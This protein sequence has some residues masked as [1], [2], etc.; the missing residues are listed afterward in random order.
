MPALKLSS[1]T[2]FTTIGWVLTADALVGAFA[3]IAVWQSVAEFG[4]QFPPALIYLLTFL[5]LAVGGFVHILR[6]Q[7]VTPAP[8]D[9]CAIVPRGGDDTHA[10]HAPVSYMCPMDS[11][12]NTLTH[13]WLKRVSPTPE[14][15]FKNQPFSRFE[16]RLTNLHLSNPSPLTTSG[17]SVPKTPRP[18]RRSETKPG[19]TP[20]SNRPESAPFNNPR[21]DYNHLPN[22]HARIV[23]DFGTWETLTWA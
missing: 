12:R 8:W 1:G 6:C 19:K 13:R 16:S 17:K 9:S 10:E 11:M 2:L 7:T 5:L 21:A 18:C 3:F 23:L 14:K 20:H 22:R 4:G 15:S